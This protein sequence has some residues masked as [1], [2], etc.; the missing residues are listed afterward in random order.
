MEEH[1]AVYDSL[2][3]TAED[4]VDA[5]RENTNVHIAHKTFLMKLESINLEKQL[6][7]YD[8]SH[9]KD[10][11]YQWARMYMNQV[12]VLLQF[13]RATREGNWFLNLAAPEKLCV[14]F[15]AY[16]RLDYAQ[17]IPEYIARMHELESIDPDIWQEFVNGEFTVNTSNE[18]PF[19]RIGVD[20]AMEH[21][22]KYTKGQGG[23]S[24]ITSYPKP[25][26]NSASPLLS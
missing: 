22:N 20:Q 12:M 7:E 17:N 5:C 14:Y 11:M 3:S 23:I 4:L 10:P 18:V 25:C 2:K 9:D 24:G 15:F 26:S 13:Q 6:L 16:N 19:T 21:L 8:A 1:P